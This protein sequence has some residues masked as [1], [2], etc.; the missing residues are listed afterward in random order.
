MIAGAMPMVLE[1]W[2]DKASSPMHAIHF[3]FG[4]GAII[5]PFIVRPF[6]SPFDE[7]AKGGL[8]NQSSTTTYPTAS[9]DVM[10]ADINLNNLDRNITSN[11]LMYPFGIAYGSTIF[12][13]L[14]F[15]LFGIFPVPKGFPVVT[16]RATLR[17]LLTPSSC[18][19]GKPGYSTILLIMLFLYFFHAVAAEHTFGT[20]VFTYV[21]ESDIHF[22][23]P[24]AAIL[25]SVYWG[26]FVIGRFSGIFISYKVAP[27][28]II[29]GCLASSLIIY[30]SVVLFSQKSIYAM[31]ILT[32]LAG[33]T[34]SLLFASG[35]LWGKKYI[36]MNSM[37][38][39]ICVSGAAIGV[40]CYFSAT[41][42]LFDHVGFHSFGYILTFYA[43]C[44]ILL[45]TVMQLFVWKC[46]RPAPSEEI[47]G[48]VPYNQVK[49]EEDQHNEDDSDESEF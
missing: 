41:G 46:G 24:T 4:F 42:Y 6:L 27:H 33:Y 1:M 48:Q 49:V 13:A 14:I 35:L 16:R 12:V 18:Y 36:R 5:S 39:M 10:T 22:S 9:M 37:A 47:E 3:G 25:N 29:S 34:N 45:F 21:V 11:Q 17:K 2:G 31:W 28:Y 7:T 44:Y 19:P 43:V 20:F 26:S 38:T 40:A 8:Y 32:I 23:K 30:V 15:S